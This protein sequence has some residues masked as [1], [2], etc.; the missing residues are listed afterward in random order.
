MASSSLSR[1]QVLSAGIFSLLLTLGV[2]R[3][4]YTPLLPL[5]QEQ[6]GLGIAEAGWL[7]AINYAGYLTGALVAFVVTDLHFKM[8]LFRWGLVMAVVSTAMMGMS[9]NLVLWMLARFL[10]GLSG[11]A[12]MLLGTGLI[13]N[14][15][16]RHNLRSELGFHFSGIGLGMIGAAVVVE[17]LSPGFDWQAQWYVFTAIAL[18]L[19]IPSLAWFPTV[20]TSPFDQTGQRLE[21]RPP[22]V[23][24]LRLF[25]AAYF[26]AGVGFVVSTTFIVAIVNRLAGLDAMG[27]IAF[28]AIGVGAAP[29]CIVWDLVA[30][31]IGTLDALILAA[32]LQV[33]G[34]L[35]PVFSHGLVT[36]L[37]G[38]VIFGATFV[39]MVSLVLTMAGRYYPTR[40]AK[41]MGKMTLAYGLAQILAP[42]ATGLLAEK[43]GDYRVGLIWAAATMVVGS[44][45][46]GM[47]RGRQKDSLVQESG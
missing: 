46:L 11:T 22:S 43:T 7:A 31:R 4:A 38:A 47:L 19:L 25:M 35:T 45:L 29:A 8:R 36:N 40:P 5:M 23:A 12:G 10:A 15:L 3:F 39:G 33:L 26:C 16:I 21:D 44:V 2:A 17:G 42:A 37:V 30:R 6:A 18:V 9:E 20:D 27:N 28:I 41:M 14:W 1:F 13:L 32:L 34:I 24:A